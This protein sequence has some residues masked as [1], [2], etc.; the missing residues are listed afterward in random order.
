M[1]SRLPL[2]IQ[3]ITLNDLLLAHVYEFNRDPF[4]R[5]VPDSFANRLYPVFVMKNNLQGD[6]VA[7]PILQDLQP[8]NNPD[9]LSILRFIDY[10]R[11][12]IDI[13]LVQCYRWMDL[14]H[15]FLLLEYDS[16]LPPNLHFPPSD[17][18]DA[19]PLSCRQALFR[20]HTL[21]S[22]WSSFVCSKIVPI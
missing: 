16:P 3:M 11:L 10:W 17:K 5:K 7:T 13:D 15:I 2:P 6:L 9:Y 4:V 21:L 22:Q 12:F 20:V 18:R 14:H 19:S 8:T 1:F